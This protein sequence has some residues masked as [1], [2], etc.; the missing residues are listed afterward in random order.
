MTAAVALR[1]TE[2]PVDQYRAAY[3]PGFDCALSTLRNTLA[4]YGYPFS[5]AMA[6]GL[7]GSFCFLYRN[8]ISALTPY[9]FLTGISHNSIEALPASLNSYLYKDKRLPG[10][11]LGPF[12]DGYL[13]RGLPVH[14]AVSRSYLQSVIHR[15][16]IAPAERALEL[17]YHYITVVRRNAEARTYTVFETDDARP[18]EIP[19]A[20]LRQAWYLDTPH[21]R[22][23]VVG[24]LACDGKWYA[25]LRPRAVEGLLPELI[26]TSLSRVVHNF[27]HPYSEDAGAAGL[28]AWREAAPRWSERTPR[29][30]SLSLL[31]A[32]VTEFNLTGGGF[33]RKLF[34]RYLREAAGQLADARL[35][36]VAR[37]FAETAERWRQLID[38][39]VATLFVDLEEDLFRPDLLALTRLLRQNVEPLVAAERRQMECLGAWTKRSG[40]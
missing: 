17:G 13:E 23:E 16:R 2:D 15:R 20:Q 11:D 35:A 27:F 26:R 25:F 3:L 1:R 36:E 29:E 5:N 31:L 10:T 33:G 39:L 18:Y 14:V 40:A 34:G 30:L 32:K 24:E 19:E 12:F 8:A 37:L 4:F 7:S 22:P 9:F 38:A 6:L 21:P 28:Q